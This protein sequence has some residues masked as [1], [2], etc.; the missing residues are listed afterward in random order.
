[1]T[2]I[3]EYQEEKNTFFIQA[4]DQN[5]EKITEENKDDFSLE[6]L[7]NYLE[8][9]D[10]KLNL[11]FIDFSDELFKNA[12]S[13]HKRSDGNFSYSCESSDSASTDFENF[14]INR[15][16]SENK[17]LSESENKNKK[18]IKM[19]DFLCQKFEDNTKNNLCLEIQKMRE[20]L[21]KE[22]M[23]NKNINIL[24]AGNDNNISSFANFSL[25]LTIQMQ[26]NY[27]NDFLQNQQKSQQIQRQMKFLCTTRNY[28][29]GFFQLQ[30]N[31][32]N[33]NMESSIFKKERKYSFQPSYNGSNFLEF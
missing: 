18:I 8:N 17:F 1:M 9:G 19:K 3:I 6:N 31:K 11:D 23:E 12:K 24:N 10:L 26:A 27:Q 5:Y 25:P 13:E 22:I 14:P 2:Q 16:S 4:I 15:T 30:Q 28:P 21:K 29:I 20:N 33:L 32:Q 7:E